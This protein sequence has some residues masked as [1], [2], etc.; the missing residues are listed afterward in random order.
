MKIS[1]YSYVPDYY[2]LNISTPHTYIYGVSENFQ[3][4]DGDF[5]TGLEV[6]MSRQ[7]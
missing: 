1:L 5:T 6:K 4:E 2:F 7:I 3:M